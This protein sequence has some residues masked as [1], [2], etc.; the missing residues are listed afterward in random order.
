MI[1]LTFKII[2]LVVNVYGIKYVKRINIQIFQINLSLFKL[3]SA[4][5]NKDYGK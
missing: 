4:K 2:L 1:V 3:T 5:E